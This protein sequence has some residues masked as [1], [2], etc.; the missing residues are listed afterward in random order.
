MAAALATPARVAV[1]AQRRKWAVV[2]RSPLQIP[3]DPWTAETLGDLRAMIVREAQNLDLNLDENPRALLDEPEVCK[4]VWPLV[5]KFFQSDDDME[6]DI[7]QFVSELVAKGSEWRFKDALIFVKKHGVRETTELHMQPVI[8]FLGQCVCMDPLNIDQ[9][10]NVLFSYLTNND[11]RIL[12]GSMQLRDDMPTIF[13]A[14]SGGGKSPMIIKL[15]LEKI[16]YK[17]KAILERIPGGLRVFLW[18]LRCHLVSRLYGKLSVQL[19]QMR[20]IS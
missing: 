1:P 15:L 4:L 19:K 11:H 20:R 2:G 7:R 18:R 17:V 8:N 14:G 5:D 3:V 10:I 9:A 16:I 12:C 6:Q 13:I